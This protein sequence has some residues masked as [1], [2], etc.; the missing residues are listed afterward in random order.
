MVG[1]SGEAMGVRAGVAVSKDWQA[2]GEDAQVLA[3]AQAFEREAPRFEAPA[4]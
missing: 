4:R 2:Q 3:W 1:G